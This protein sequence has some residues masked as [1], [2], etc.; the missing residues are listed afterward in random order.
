MPNA[1]DDET[2]I[3]HVVDARTAVMYNGV[4]YTLLAALG[5]GLYAAITQGALLPTPLVVIY[6]GPER[7]N[8]GSAYDGPERRAA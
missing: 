3:A 5:R 7:R 4:S 6:A 2:T 8:G 1:P